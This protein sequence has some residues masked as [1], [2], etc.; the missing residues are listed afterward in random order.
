M[1]V[2]QDARCDD[3]LVIHPSYVV[4]DG[5]WWG[6]LLLTTVRRYALAVCTF[7]V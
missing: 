4:I 3:L 6:I 5:S 7:V 1:S 2:A